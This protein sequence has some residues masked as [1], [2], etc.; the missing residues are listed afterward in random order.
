MYICLDLQKPTYRKS[1][2]LDSSAPKAGFTGH[3]NNPRSRKEKGKD[4]K[5]NWGSY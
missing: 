4:R 2:H 3:E 1:G 5:K